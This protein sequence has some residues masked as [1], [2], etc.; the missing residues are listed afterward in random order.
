ML[1]ESDSLGAT[2]LRLKSK[3]CG[4]F[5][6]FNVINGNIKTLRIVEFPKVSIKMK[7]FKTFYD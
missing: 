3:F 4:K 6:R 5:Q 1:R 2:I 7:I